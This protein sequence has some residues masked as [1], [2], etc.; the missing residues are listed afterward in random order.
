MGAQAL[1]PAAIGRGLD[2]GVAD[3]DVSAAVKWSLVVLFLACLQAVAGVLRHRIA[4]QNWLAALFRSM[5]LLGRH[6]ALVGVAIRRK[7]PTGEV[8]SAPRPTTR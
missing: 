1:V 5:Q 6:S 4:V 2:Q 7:L 3:D 8:V